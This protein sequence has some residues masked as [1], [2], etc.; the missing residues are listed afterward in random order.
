MIDVWTYGGG[1]GVEESRS[2]GVE[3]SVV[4]VMIEIRLRLGNINNSCY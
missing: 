4:D 3:G 1:G 2:R